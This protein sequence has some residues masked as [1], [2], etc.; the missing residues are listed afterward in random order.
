ML[1]HL[2]NPQTQNTIF[3]ILLALAVILTSRKKT[4]NTI[5]SIETTNELKGLAILSVIFIHVGYFLTSN[6][7]FLFPLSTFGGVG[8]NIFLFLSGFGLTMSALKKDLSI[9]KFYLKRLSKV[10]IPVWIF[11][12]IFLLLDKFALGI[13][14]PTA[15]TIRNF[16]GFFPQADLFHDINSPLWFITPLVLYYLLFPLLFRKKI[17]ELTALAFY[18]IYYY[19]LKYFIPDEVNE[20]VKNL[21]ILHY[22]AFPLGILF[23]SILTRLKNYQQFNNLAIKLQNKRL[24]SITLRSF[25]LCLMALVWY[26]F[27]KNSGVGEDKFTEQLY[28]IIAMFIT[29]FIFILKPIKNQFLNLLGVFSFELYLL[30]WPLM[31]RYDFIFRFIPAGLAMFLY[32]LVFMGIGW[33]IKNLPAKIKSLKKSSI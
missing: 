3:F 30:H 4:D 29:I 16:F 10:I 2:F 28:S 23:A 1:T 19:L 20:G 8:V 33:G 31:N 9:S 12:I 27:F 6:N 17:P 24:I 7:Q 18:I 15:L 25:V 22:W 13:T 32:L 5:L 21:W 11:L 14:Y 26:Y